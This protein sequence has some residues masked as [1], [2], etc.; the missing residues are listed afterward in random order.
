MEHRSQ[1]TGT[2]CY[3]LL[4]LF[5]QQSTSTKMCKVLLINCV[6]EEM[7]P[8]V[9]RVHRSIMYGNQI[10]KMFVFGSRNLNVVDGRGRGS[11]TPL[12]F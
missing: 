11:A 12:K 2:M 10:T 8:R 7:P 9:N 4:E 3:M 6:R 5:Y 1:N